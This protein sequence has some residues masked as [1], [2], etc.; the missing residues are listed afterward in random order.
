MP[1]Y[2]TE[3]S[4]HFSG[5]LLLD[6]IQGAIKFTHRNPENMSGKARAM[7]F[8]VLVPKVVFETPQITATIQ[9][10][11]DGTSQIDINAEACQDALK[12]VIGTDIKIEVHDIED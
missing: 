4:Y 12:A 6:P 9:V 2:S 8:R 3:H 11:G 1:V 5:Y 10:K 7:A